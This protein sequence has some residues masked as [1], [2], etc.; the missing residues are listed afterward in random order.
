[1]KMECHSYEIGDDD[2]HQWHMVK[3]MDFLQ[4]STFSSKVVVGEDGNMEVDNNGGGI[5]DDNGDDD[6]KLKID[7]CNRKL[8]K[9]IFH[10][11]CLFFLLLFGVDH[12][13]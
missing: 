13:V 3:E 10:N 6:L 11:F 9:Y 12:F 7:V 2:E 1:M 8:V 4:G 5:R